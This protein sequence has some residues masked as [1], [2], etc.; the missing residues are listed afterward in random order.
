MLGGASGPTVGGMTAF[1]RG[2]A[3]RIEP[4]ASSHSLI[5][6]DGVSRRYEMGEVTVTALADVDLAG[7]L[8][9]PT[10]R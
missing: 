10:P 3:A 5:A 1:S 6:L 7:E 8:A 4:S 2:A 9:A